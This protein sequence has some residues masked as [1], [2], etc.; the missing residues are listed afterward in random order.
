MH[1]KDI[2]FYNRAP[3]DSL[4]LTFEENAIT[5]FTAVNGKGKTTIL[6]YI[7]DAWVEITRRAYPQ[8]YKGKEDDYYRISSDIHLINTNAP[9]FVYIRFMHEDRPYDYLDYRNGLPENV[10]DE[11]VT[12]DDKIKY[13]DIK[14]RIDQNPSAKIID[15]RLKIDTIKQIFDSH[16]MTYMPSY[17]SEI[18]N[19][20][21]DAYK[22]KWEHDLIMKYSGYLHN[23]LEVSEGMHQFANWLLDL[24][25]DYALFNK[26]KIGPD[27]IPENIVW[28]NVNVILRKAL[29]SKHPDEDI[30]F[31][32]GRRGSGAERISILR[33]SEDRLLYP[34]LFGL[35]TG[36]QSMLMMFGEIIR[37]ADVL[38]NNIKLENV[39]GVVLIDEIDKNLHLRLQKEVLP[40]LMQLFPKL[41]FIVT[42]H[43]PFLNMGL[44]D[45]VADRAQIVDLDNGGVV[46]T[47]TNNEVYQETYEMFLK[48]R[49]HFADEYE[50]VS[51]RLKQLVRPVV[52]TEGKTDIKHIL[53]AMEKL[54]I[55]QKFDILDVSEQPDGEGNLKQI[56]KNLK[57]IK[58]NRKVIA[59][60]DRD[61]NGTKDIEDPYK[62][63]GNN[64]YALRIKCPKNR[65][66]K[67]RTAISIE[68][69]Y[70]DDEI[71]SVLPNKCQL[72]FGNEFKTDSTRRHL[73]NSELRLS[74]PDGCGQDKII[75]NNG[76]Q[77]VFDNDDNNHL[78][79]KN[80][81]A[82][83]IVN[84]K[85]EISQQSWENFRPTIDVINQIIDL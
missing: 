4:H 71:H 65:V 69:M 7:M 22:T 11:N 47:P 33:N 24:L 3:F 25:L 72:F 49:N 58:Q 29:I 57:L 77:A 67:G 10:Y 39:V 38:R 8:S 62:D 76:G 32:A 81:F 40:E 63:Y 56:I 34:S 5:V 28:E 79:K 16:V 6:S 70:T 73:V 74:L 84:D 27:P 35:S 19:Y 66:D 78:A 82:D 48:E 59:V 15:G 14:N 44:A 54:G 64:V 13:S 50:K 60:F 45:K 80:D 36:E 30:R 9:S 53:K 12:L 52:I 20:L 85:I 26:E 2:F 75:E 1:V 37:Q 43:S 46:T 31:G 42:S 23:P 41:Q 55:E 51:G 18:P 68:Y 17:R 83:A 61:T 21:N